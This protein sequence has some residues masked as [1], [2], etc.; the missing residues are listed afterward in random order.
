MRP[1][2]FTVTGPT[3]VDADIPFFETFKR[4]F[5]PTLMVFLKKNPMLTI[6]LSIA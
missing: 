5:L 2:L 3:F 4:L 6:N 1:R